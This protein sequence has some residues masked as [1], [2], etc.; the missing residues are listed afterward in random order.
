MQNDIYSE[1]FIKEL[2]KK[3][4]VEN[5]NSLDIC[6]TKRMLNML[7]FSLEQAD[8]LLHNKTTFT[9]DDILD[10]IQQL[11]LQDDDNYYVEFDVIKS[12]LQTTIDNITSSVILRETY[13]EIKNSC[14]K[15]NINK[16]TSYIKKNTEL[17]ELNY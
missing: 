12:Y 13:G 9:I 1:N 8:G 14:Q 10:I 4:D 15:V 5:T 3:I 6:D 7:G 11:I 16:L 17:L 2:F